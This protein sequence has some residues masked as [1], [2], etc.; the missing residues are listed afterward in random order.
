MNNPQQFMQNFAQPTSSL[1]QQTGN[2]WGNFL[3]QP[4]AQQRAMEQASPALLQQLQGT[5][6]QGVLNAASPI[7]Q[8]NLQQGADI[9]R[10]SGPRFNSNTERLVADQSGKAMQDFN[11]FTQNVMES[12]LQRQIGAAGTLG[13]LAQGVDQNQLAGLQGAGNFANQMQGNQMNLIGPLLQQMFGAAFGGGGI[14]TP[15]TLQETKPW[16]Q[17]GLGALGQ[18]GSIAAQAKSGGLFGGGNNNYGQ[19]SLFG[20]GGNGPY[21]G[22][23]TFNPQ[24]FM[25]NGWQPSGMGTA[26]TPQQ[27]V[28]AAPQGASYDAW[29]KQGQASMPPGAKWTAGGWTF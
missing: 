26:A 19:G 6:G 1:Q 2:L 8:R 25:Y 28:A 4:S 24:P 18:I 13:Q 17:Q 7:F 22:G 11:L 5:P 29:A 3:S 21:Q 10:Q 15:A 9:L 16:W 12:G 20:G 14:Q 27:G 23:P